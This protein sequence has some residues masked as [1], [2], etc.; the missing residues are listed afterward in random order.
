[1]KGKVDFNAQDGAVVDPPS[2]SDPMPEMI[3]IVYLPQVECEVT[4]PNAL[5]ETEIVGVPD[6]R[7]NHQFLRVGKGFVIRDNGKTYLP[8]GL[9][10]LDRKNRRALIEL[11]HEADSGVRRL[12]VPFERFRHQ[13][14]SP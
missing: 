2:R 8:V 12:W 11:P 5:F 6:E 14:E 13:K 7:D 9:V 10:E 3:D 1:M 4:N